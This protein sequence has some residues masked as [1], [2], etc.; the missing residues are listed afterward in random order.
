MRK[1]NLLFIC[2]LFFFACTTEERIIEKKDNL[3]LLQLPTKKIEVID[4]EK[5]GINFII[6][7]VTA[8]SIQRAKVISY[9]STKSVTDTLHT[10]EISTKYPSV[11]DPFLTRLVIKL[12]KNGEMIAS[13]FVG[14]YELATLKYNKD[15]K[16]VDVILPEDVNSGA[17]YARGLYF[18]KQDL[19]YDCINK[20][21]KRLK[22]LVQNDMAND[23]ICTITMPICET[24]LVMAAIEKCR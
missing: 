9:D 11:E 1:L 22:R 15:G 2:S 6:T 10:Y 8:T 13:H 3:S 14:D 17:A 23:V 20:E 18:S 16:I 7:P 19:T 24:L 21:Y 12:N 5:T 4:Y